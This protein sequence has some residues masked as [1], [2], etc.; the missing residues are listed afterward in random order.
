ME[1]VELMKRIKKNND[2]ICILKDK[3]KTSARRYEE[4]GMIYGWLRNHKVRILYH[5]GVPPERLIK[6]YPDTRR[7]SR[8]KK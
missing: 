8:E 3:V 6:Y 2:K 1:D 4:E 7:K 5:L